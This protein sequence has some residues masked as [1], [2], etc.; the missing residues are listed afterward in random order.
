MRVLRLERLLTPVTP[1]I[2][3]FIHDHVGMVTAASIPDTTFNVDTDT[4]WLAGD[5]VAVAATTRT[6]LETTLYPLNANAGASSFTSALFQNNVQQNASAFSYTTSGTS[7]TQAEIGLLTR[8][9]KIRATTATF[10]TF[11]YCA[12]LATVTVSWA[13]FYRVGGTGV[14]KRGIEFDTGATANPKSFT[15]C[16]MHDFTSGSALYTYWRQHVTQR[17][18]C[19]QHHLVFGNQHQFRHQYHKH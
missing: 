14:G 16:S 4:G 5:V 15:Y 7:P 10:G 11:F 6:N 17:H 12:A 19:E 1:P 2:G 9:V 13:E 3:R 18:V 8:N